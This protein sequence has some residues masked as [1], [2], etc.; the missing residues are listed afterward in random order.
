[1]LPSLGGCQLPSV[2]SG[3]GCPSVGSLLGQQS[4]MSVLGGCQQVIRLL[5]HQKGKA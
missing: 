1:M 5:C 4:Q 2:L 3:S